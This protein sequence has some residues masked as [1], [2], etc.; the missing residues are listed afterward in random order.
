MTR[1]KASGADLLAA[2]AIGATGVLAKGTVSPP[3][4]VAADRNWLCWF[5][6]VTV[7]RLRRRPWGTADAVGS[8]GF[9]GG[10]LFAVSTGSFLYAVVLVPVATAVLIGAMLPVLAL[11][12]DAYRRRQLP[13]PAPAL[14]A[15]TAV[16][17]AAL[18]ATGG[19]LKGGAAVVSLVSGTLY[20]QVSKDAR[21]AGVAA[22]SYTRRTMLVSAAALTTA[23]LLH[24]DVPVLPETADW[25]ILPALALASAV[26][27]ALFAWGHAH[28]PIT[29]SAT[30]QLCVPIFA[31]V[32][33]WLFLDEGLTVMQLTGGGVLLGA[34][35]A[36]VTVSDRPRGV[37]A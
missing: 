19:D 23:A 13:A 36:L 30:L 37:A 18:L 33:A 15:L 31:A 20:W 7:S 28:L 8:R 4:V 10:L 3:L 14:L 35:I 25:R 2:A 6:F 21:D 26:G 27:Q 22:T 17:G 9:T 5:G 29:V 16:A 11:P 1:L 24:P 34:L 32:F 12:L